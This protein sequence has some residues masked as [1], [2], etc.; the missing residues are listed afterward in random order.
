VIVRTKIRLIVVAVAWAVSLVGV[1][2]WAQGNQ[3]GS[4]TPGQSVGI[5]KPYGEIIVGENI[6][7]QRIANPHDRASQVTGRLMVKIDGVWKEA[8]APIGLVR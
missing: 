2:L 6:G 3:S 7:F 5:G 8:V 4:V 1:A